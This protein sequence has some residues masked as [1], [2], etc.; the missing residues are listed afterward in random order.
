MKKIILIVCVAVLAFPQ[1]TT[2]AHA[3]DI[4]P[5]CNIGRECLEDMVDRYAEMYNVSA[6]QMKAVITCESNWN[7][8]IQ[9]LH[10][11]S[12]GREQSFGLAQIHAPSHPDVTYEQATDPEFAINFMADAFSKGKQGMWS[13]YKKLYK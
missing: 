6:D 8:T 7:P 11:N 2:V 9:S 13:C 5:L 4:P 3:E 1:S 12:G 10:T